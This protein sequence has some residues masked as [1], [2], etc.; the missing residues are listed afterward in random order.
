MT[1]ESALK[2]V[3]IQVANGHE[4]CPTASTTDL[5]IDYHRVILKLYTHGLNRTIIEWYLS[6]ILT[7]SPK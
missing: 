2:P 4:D 7:E 6:L 5:P 3:R 1:I